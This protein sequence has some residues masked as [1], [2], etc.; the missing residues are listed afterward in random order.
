MPD[1]ATAVGNIGVRGG[2]ATV[3]AEELAPDEQPLGAIKATA[4]DDTDRSLDATG[5]H[6]SGRD[7]RHAD[8]ESSI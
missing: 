1:A 4:E 2:T 8:Q 5:G 3:L 6:S 7:H